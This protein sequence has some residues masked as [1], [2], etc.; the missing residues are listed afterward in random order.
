M[1]DRSDDVVYM[2]D[3]KRSVLMDWSLCWPEQWAPGSDEPSCPE[4][5]CPRRCQGLLE[6]QD[7]YPR[8]G[9]RPV[10]GIRLF[11]IPGVIGID[12]G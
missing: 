12:A 4:E 11:E 8:M 3:H 9:T 10:H 1:E 2:S 5:G 6:F 7:A